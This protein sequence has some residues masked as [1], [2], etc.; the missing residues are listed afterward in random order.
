MNKTISM[1]LVF[2]TIFSD[3]AHII[4]NST[5]STDIPV[6]FEEMTFRRNDDYGRTFK[7]MYGESNGICIG[8]L[9]DLYEKEEMQTTANLIKED[10]KLLVSTLDIDEAEEIKIYVL[11]ETIAGD[12][13]SKNNSVYCTKE[14]LII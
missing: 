6:I 7:M 3:C 9:K 4:E 10:I 5:N 2:I 12:S 13:Y 8:F 11:E 1:L 14:Y